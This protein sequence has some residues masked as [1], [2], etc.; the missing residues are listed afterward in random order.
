MNGHKIG[1][2]QNFKHSTLRCVSVISLHFL[3]FI[4]CQ[5][6]MSCFLLSTVSMC[7]CHNS[8]KDESVRVRLEKLHHF[9]VT[10]ADINHLYDESSKTYIYPH[11]RQTIS[12]HCQGK[13]K[14]DYARTA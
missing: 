7:V 6:F 10:I 3:S 11:T 14:Y 13:V 12:H 9:A 4:L 5:I 8:L 1:V 2:M